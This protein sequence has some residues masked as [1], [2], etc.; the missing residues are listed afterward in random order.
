M[1]PVSDVI[2]LPDKLYMLYIIVFYR[3]MMM[4]KDDDDKLLIVNFA[5]SFMKPSVTLCTNQLYATHLPRYTTHSTA[6]RTILNN[7]KFYRD[8]RNVCIVY[9]VCG[10]SSI[11]NKKRIY[12]LSLY[13]QASIIDNALKNIGPIV[14][15]LHEYIFLF[16]LT[17]SLNN[18]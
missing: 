17:L 5:E 12:F 13:L 10:F 18:I 3:W 1:K 8:I 16:F 11:I 15:C 14:V 6:T 7:M 9:V 2:V 4:Q